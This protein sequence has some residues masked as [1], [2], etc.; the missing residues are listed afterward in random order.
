MQTIPSS[1]MI[2]KLLPT[3]HIKSMVKA[4]KSAGLTLEVSWSDGTVIARYGKLEVYRA[5]QAGNRNAQWIV[6]HHNRL[7][8]A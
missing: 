7:F 2:T 3:L 1:K 4:M 6:R 5:I 8:E